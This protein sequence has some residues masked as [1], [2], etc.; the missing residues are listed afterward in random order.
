VDAVA[1]HREQR[2]AVGLGDV[3]LV[4][5]RLLVVGRR[6]VGRADRLGR[7]RRRGGGRRLPLDQRGDDDPGPALGLLQVALG[8]ADEARAGVERAQAVAA[9]VG[10]ARQRDQRDEDRGERRADRYPSTLA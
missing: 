7:R 1:R 6:V 5:A 10:G 2:V 9:R 3:G 8:I 4:D